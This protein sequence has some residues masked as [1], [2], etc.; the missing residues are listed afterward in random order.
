M[1]KCEAHSETESDSLSDLELRGSPSPAVRRGGNL[2]GRGIANP[3]L[4]DNTI[5]INK[6]NRRQIICY[7]RK[8]AFVLATGDASALTVL[9]GPQRRHA[10]EALTVLSKAT[11]CYDRWCEIRKRYQL[12]WTNGD[13]S[14]A[15][16]QRFFDASLTLD[17]MVSKVKEMI[18]V[19]SPSMADVIRFAVLTGLRPAESCESVRLINK[20]PGPGQYYNQQQQCLEH[21]RFSQFLRPTKKAFISYLSTSNYRWIASLG[22]C[23]PTLAAI[24]SAC[25][26]RKIPCRLHLTRKV[27]AS[28][29]R[30]KGIEPEVVDLLQGRVSQST[31][32]RHYQS[33]DSTLKQRVLDAVASL[34]IIL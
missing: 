18:A 29:L 9:T 14:I 5:I 21:F 13:E 7:A 3:I 22:P 15:A 4:C 34:E 12:H 6:R 2:V 1:F 33:P 20:C 27:F 16:M 8:Y 28:Y 32:V 17:S 19:L 30:H 23:T 11:G 25:K 26:R 31:L 10:M 24:S